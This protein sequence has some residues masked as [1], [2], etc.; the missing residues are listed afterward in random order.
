MWSRDPVR[1]NHSSPDRGGG[2]RAG[3]HAGRGRAPLHGCGGPLLARAQIHTQPPAP[4]AAGKLLC[5]SLIKTKL[6]V[7]ILQPARRVGTLGLRG[8]FSGRPAPFYGSSLCLGQVCTQP[9]G[10]PVEV[11]QITVN[12]C[13]ISAKA[14]PAA[15]SVRG[16]RHGVSPW[17]GQQPGHQHGL[18]PLR[19]QPRALQPLPQLR[20]PQPVQRS[21]G[22]HFTL[23]SRKLLR[24][25]H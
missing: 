23:K 22:R 14:V 16:V 2:S 15:R 6:L 19:A 11:L 24:S 13:R 18:G 4:P 5:Q 7:S 12:I 10:S 8:N 17:P 1:T 9:P 25:L 21:R 3:G 20:H